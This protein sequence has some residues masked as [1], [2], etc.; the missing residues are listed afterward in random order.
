MDGD[1]AVKT[2][3]GKQVTTAQLTPEV[4]QKM[5]EYAK[6]MSEVLD[7]DGVGYHMPLPAR[8]LA[9]ANGL[10]AKVGANLNHEQM[11]RLGNEVT[12]VLVSS[13]LGL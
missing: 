12:K 3:S 2:A 4:K 1:V 8:N 13:Y 6:F 11:T 7:Q 5:D 9:E 10:Q